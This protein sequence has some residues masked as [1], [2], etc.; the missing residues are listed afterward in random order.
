MEEFHLNTFD[1]FEGW[2]SIEC[3]RNMKKKKNL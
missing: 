2:S 3:F 1:H